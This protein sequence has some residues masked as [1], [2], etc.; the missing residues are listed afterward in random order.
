MKIKHSF[1]SPPYKVLARLF[2][3]EALNGETNFLS[4]F[5]GDVLDRDERSEFQRLSQVSFSHI[6]P[7][8][9]Y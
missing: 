1:S 7:D 3:K 5:M 2:C 4:K 8:L 9:V 6:D